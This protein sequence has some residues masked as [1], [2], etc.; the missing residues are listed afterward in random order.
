MYYTKNYL[1]LIYKEVLVMQ[2]ILNI[3]SIIAFF[4]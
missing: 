3:N 2:K 4:L 1:I